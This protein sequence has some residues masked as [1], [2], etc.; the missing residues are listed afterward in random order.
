MKS[1]IRLGRGACTTPRLNARHFERLIVGRI[2]SSTL[3]EG[4]NGDLTKVVVQ[5]VDR[6][7]QEQR[8]LLETIESEIMNA[9]RRM[10]RLFELLETSDDD[11]GNL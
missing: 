4:N 5:E 8:K 3:T 10:D 2:R 1:L 7:A 6:V 9:H 11:I